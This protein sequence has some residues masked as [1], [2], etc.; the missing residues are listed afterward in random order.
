MKKYYIY[1]Y[2]DPRKPGEFTYNDLNFKFEPFYVGKGTDK[3]YM[4]HIWELKQDVYN[5]IRKGKI[6]HIFQEGLEPIIEFV[7]FEIEEDALKLEIEYIKKIGRINT[8]TGPLSNLTDGGDGLSSEYLK[9]IHWTPERRKKKSESQIGENNAMFGRSFYDCWIVKYGKEDAD[10]KLVAFK[11]KQ[12]NN[13]KNNLFT[14]QEKKSIKEHLIEKFGQD[15]YKEWE[16]NLSNKRRNISKKRFEEGKY[17]ERKP[18]NKEHIIELISIGKTSSE[19]S[20]ELNIS[21][22][23]LVTKCKKY[24]NKTI[25]ELRKEHRFQE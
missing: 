13:S 23:T 18:I 1:I 4:D 10:K 17:K 25:Y 22:N 21:V 14:N 6:K 8:N 3:R 19:I 11:E 15:Y 24:F 2:L 20:K 12:K 16:E 9:N 5:K 7:Y